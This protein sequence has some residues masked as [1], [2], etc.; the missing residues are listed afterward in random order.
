[1]AS[2]PYRVCA[3]PGCSVVSPEARCPAHQRTQRQ[4]QRRFQTGQT[5]Y[6]SVRWVRETQRF[7][8]L[9]PHCVNA[10]QDPRCTLLTDVTDH[11]VPHRGDPVL[12]WDETNWQPM[13][14]TCHSRKTALETR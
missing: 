1:M 10:G 8:A 11:K 7:K 13:C 5:A 9:H 12:F 2:R 4:Q 6:N 3:E 14:A